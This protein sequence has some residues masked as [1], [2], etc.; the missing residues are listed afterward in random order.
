MTAVL[1]KNVCVKKRRGFFLNFNTSYIHH[2]LKIHVVA[3]QVPGPLFHRPV[4][5]NLIQDDISPVLVGPPLL[6]SK[7][8]KNEDLQKKNKGIFLFFFFFWG[9]GVGGVPRLK[10]I[11]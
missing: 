2:H 10:K 7:K 9:G 4:L 1:I 3:A 6:P 5:E 8:K 11:A